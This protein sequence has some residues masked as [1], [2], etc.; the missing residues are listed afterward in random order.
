MY[1]L[2]KLI[3]ADIPISYS[4]PDPPTECWPAWNEVST[5]KHIEI[6]VLNIK[7]IIHLPILY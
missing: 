5:K 4:P 1:I 2:W 3:N 6:N 7:I